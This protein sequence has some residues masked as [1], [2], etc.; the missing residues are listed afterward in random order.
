MAVICGVGFA[1]VPLLF[2]AYLGLHNRLLMDD[3]VYIGLARDIGTWKAMLA[4]REFWNGGYSNFLLYGL[5]APL[6]ASAPAVFS[7]IL[8]ASAFVGFGWLVNTLLTSLGIRSHRPAIVVTLASLTTAAVING[9]FHAQVFYWLTGAVT[10]NWPAVMLLLG[11]ALSAATAHRLRGRIQHILA[12]VA[13]A[14]YAF[15]SAGFSEMYLVFQL[16]AV[17]L[18]AVY[19]FI[20]QYRPKHNSY[21]VLASAAC[22]GTSV[23]LLAQMAAP[24]FANRSAQTDYF[25]VPIVPVRDLPNLIIRTLDLTLE[26][27]GHQTSFAGFMLVAFTGL[28]LTLSVGKRSSIDLKPWNTTTA[29]APIAFAL[30]V[31]L[32]FAPILLTHSSDNLQV[33]GRFSH[34]FA[35][36]TGINLLTLAILLALLWRRD[37]LVKALKR[38]NGLVIYCLCVL[39]LVCL[40][41]V[42]TQVRSIHYKA[43]TY[44]FIS[45]LSTLIMLAGQ[46]TCMADEP[47]MRRL[48][49][50]SAFASAA[51]FLTLAALLAAKLWGLG[52]IVERTLT[53]AI[54]ALMLAGLI[55]GVTL[56]ALIR[57]GCQTTNADAFWLRWI[58]LLCLVGA[59]SI[60]AGIVIGQW[61]RISSMQ[62]DVEI[63]ESAHQE[64][65]KLRDEGDPIIYTKKFPHLIHRSLDSIPSGY[66]NHPLLWEKTIYYGLQFSDESYYNCSCS[67]EVRSRSETEKSCTKFICLAYGKNG[68]D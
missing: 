62:R 41:F 28:F 66:R 16:A 45:S 59:L 50:L 54:Y 5:L 37:L 15:I 63:W 6:D 17:A 30:G 24:G 46:L 18:I 32:S 57:L 65:I 67:N 40:F 27:S 36:V 9:F 2:F 43:S 61:P 39:L 22:L 53:S 31:Q 49:R 64:I 34:A 23:S 14:F 21:R 60:A 35:L 12:A 7:L 68:R 47:R 13:A 42:M 51:A 11:I 48:F 25:G 19:V 8:C 52:I 1:L 56:G 55:I 3:Y 33:L 10:Y 58:R 44:S 38:H 20:F 29:A 26:Y 4:W